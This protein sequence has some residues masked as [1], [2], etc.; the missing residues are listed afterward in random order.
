MT[1]PTDKEDFTP[2]VSPEFTRDNHVNELQTLLET[3]QNVLGL[4]VNGN[5]GAKVHIGDMYYGKTQ[6]TKR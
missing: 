1:Y 5:A 6:R 4:L 2:V 3:L